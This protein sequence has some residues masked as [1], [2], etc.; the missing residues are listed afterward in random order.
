ML[1]CSPQVVGRV[2]TLYVYHRW[3]AGWLTCPF[4]TGDG[5]GDCPVF[6][7]QV[8]KQ[9]G[10]RLWLWWLQLKGGCPLTAGGGQGGCLF[11]TGEEQ[12]SCPVFFPQVVCRALPIYYRWWVGWLPVYPQIVVRAA[13]VFYPQVRA[14]VDVCM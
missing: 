2:A 5:Q 1:A 8:G 11:T 13:A 10:C 12:G 7:P 4:T 3:L 6:Y 9:G 14:R